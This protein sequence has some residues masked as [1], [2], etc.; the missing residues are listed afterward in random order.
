MHSFD[1]R[2]ALTAHGGYFSDE[3]QVEL[4]YPFLTSTPTGLCRILTVYNSSHS[5]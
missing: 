5:G 4:P 2:L 1:R 3:I